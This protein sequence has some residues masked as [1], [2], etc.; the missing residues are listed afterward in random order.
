MSYNSYVYNFTTY[1]YVRMV[2][3]K[4]VFANVGCACVIFIVCR[5]LRLTTGCLHVM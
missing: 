1:T 5:T 4:P 3:L 2:E